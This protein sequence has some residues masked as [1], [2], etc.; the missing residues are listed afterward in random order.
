[1]RCQVV[2]IARMECSYSASDTAWAPSLCW[3]AITDDD[4]VCDQRHALFMLIL[5]SAIISF[6]TNR[7]AIIAHRR[8][9]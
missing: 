7:D 2:R 4:V 9:F 1:M 3:A 6:S 8:R 5:F